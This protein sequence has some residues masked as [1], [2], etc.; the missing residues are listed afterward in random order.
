MIQKMVF[1]KNKYFFNPSYGRM[2][3][4]KSIN[5]FSFIC[6][7]F[8]LN[9]LVTSSCKQFLEVGSPKDK[10]TPE[11]MFE[12]DAVAISAVTG[13]Y[14]RM[15]A[16]YGGGFSGSA[17][18][19]SVIAGLTSD[20]LISHSPEFEVFQKNEIP[21]NNYV[22][23]AYIWGEAYQY[24]YTCN[25][26]LQGLKSAPGVSEKTKKQI[27]GEAKFVRAF[28]YFYL[29]NLFGE[30]P[31]NLVTDYRTTKSQARAPLANVINQII[32]DLTDA[33][34]LLQET[35][36]SSER[37]RPNKWAATFLLSRVYLFNGNWQLAAQK[38]SEVIANQQMYELSDVNGVFLRESKETI[39]QLVPAAGNNSNE[40]T[41]FI[42]TGA[43]T[44]FSLSR[45][46]VS[47]F[48]PNDKRRANWIGKLDDASG[49]YYFAH[50]YKALSS[51]SISEYSIVLRLA[52]L[53]LIRSE[54]NAKL[55]KNEE[56]MSDLNTLRKRAGLTIP[57]TGLTT[58]DLMT[59]VMKQRRL[60]LFSE[61]GH[62]WLDLKRTTTASAV[63]TQLKG[64]T[65][66]EH[67][68]LYPIPLSEIRSNPNVVPNQGY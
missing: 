34:S 4:S 50:K 51:P 19:I 64:S 37:A 26:V 20:E 3:I 30:V 53:Y 65:W 40:S 61:W 11:N 49:E 44:S 54:A 25:A 66:S 18:S 16:L 52:E 15:V 59:E 24:V 14:T 60:E 21:S 48:D 2:K 39:W 56:A 57:L 67:D 8:V 58:S 28:C 12:N 31:L 27:M 38:A 33:E 43:P 29:Y 42:L 5:R 10:A 13:I 35:Y 36:V 68:L 47:L 41:T 32:S 46:L 23:E 45:D 17:N 9:L 63:L 6:I 7:L 22:I 55:L 1:T 62:R